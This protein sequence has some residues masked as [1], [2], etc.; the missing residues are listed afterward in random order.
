MDFV[1]LT[2]VFRELR[3]KKGYYW[4]PRGHS[5][6]AHRSSFTLSAHWSP[7]TSTATLHIPGIQDSDKAWL[8]PPLCPKLQV[9]MLGPSGTG[10]IQSPVMGYAMNRFISLISS[11]VIV[12]QRLWMIRYTSIIQETPLFSMCWTRN[13]RQNAS[14][15]LILPHGQC[16]QTLENSGKL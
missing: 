16:P 13:W 2:D 3:N 12:F 4:A 15:F 10:P 1:N 5:H 9:A 14:A 8:P 6:R 7:S 11:G